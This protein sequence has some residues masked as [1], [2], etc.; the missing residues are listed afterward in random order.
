MAKTFMCG[1]CRKLLLRLDSK[2]CV[3]S[4]VY[5]FLLRFIL[6]DGII[7]IYFYVYLHRHKARLYLLVFTEQEI[8]F[9][10]K[11]FLYIAFKPVAK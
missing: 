9:I 6:Y 5:Q 2:C 4:F 3:Y 1:R 8:I 7:F 11:H 10:G